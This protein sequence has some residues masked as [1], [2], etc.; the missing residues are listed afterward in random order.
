M[1]G[2]ALAIVF[3]T[4]AAMHAVYALYG[5]TGRYAADV[6]GLG[7]DMLAV[8]AGIYFLWVVVALYRG[9]F[10]DWNGSPLRAGASA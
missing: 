8:P 3:P 4:C 2:L 9:T 5:L 7:I 1:S 10:V 6:H